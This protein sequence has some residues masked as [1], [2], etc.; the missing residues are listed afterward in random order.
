MASPFFYPQSRIAV[1]SHKT[2][3]EKSYGEKT[4]N[5]KPKTFKIATTLII[6]IFTF[7]VSGC[8]T[9]S[10]R[11][12][13][14]TGALIG[15]G[16]GAVI[17]QSQ[18]KEGRET[19]ALIGAATGATIGLLYLKTKKMKKEKSEKDMAVKEKSD[20]PDRENGFHNPDKTPDDR[21]CSGSWVWG[22]KEEYWI[23][24]KDEF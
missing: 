23:C 12:A 17:G 24:E 19:G 22:D 4:M 14:T 3:E 21:F 7:T 20:R 8:A 16:T 18:G 1:R 11:R 6:A 15:A 10:E 2:G 5:R 9:D 13:I